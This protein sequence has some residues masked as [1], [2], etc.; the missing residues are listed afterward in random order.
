MKAKR[1]QSTG[2]TA[3]DGTSNHGALSRLTTVKIVTVMVLWAACFPLIKAGIDRAPHLT[4]AALGAGLAGMA[5]IGAATAL[6][7]PRPTGARHWGLL[8]VAG[9]GATTLGFFGMFHAAEFISPGL[10]TV[11]ANTQPLLAAALAYVT[12]GESLGRSGAAGLAIG[13]AGIIVIAAPGLTANGTDNYGLGI[14]YVLLA[15]AGI[16]I[17]NVAFKRLAGE[18]DP[19]MAAGA[20]LLIGTGPLAVLAAVTEDPTW[21]AWSPIFVV[22]V[23][24][25][26]LPGTA[27][28]YGLWVS[29]LETTP[30]NKANAFSF[31]VPIL[32]MAM[33]IAFYGEPVTVAVVIGSATV[34]AGLAIVHQ[35]E[36][37]TAPERPRR[38]RRPRSP[39]IHLHRSESHAHEPRSTHR[40]TRSDDPRGP[41]RCRAGL[42]ELA[43]RGVAGHRGDDRRRDLRPHRPSRRAGR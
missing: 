29:V 25:L 15:A 1:Q 37:S 31:L 43:R 21:I 26:A 27:I 40:P 23:I 10:A 13:F 39:T 24:G 9:V 16:T 42:V 11:I 18:V 2:L 17:S 19:L 32:G 8:T 7:R 38:G 14:A 6:G 28:V 34:L 33:G 30:L 20:Q 22:S 41:R 5:L 3:P 36:P 4:F 12:L 35:A